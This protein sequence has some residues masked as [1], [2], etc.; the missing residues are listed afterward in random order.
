MRMSDYVGRIFR[1]GTVFGS[2][3]EEEGFE[4]QDVET[5][6]YIEI[7]AVAPGLRYPSLVVRPPKRDRN[8]E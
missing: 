6:E 2:G 3:E 7:Q 5:G 1:V 4:L 8:S